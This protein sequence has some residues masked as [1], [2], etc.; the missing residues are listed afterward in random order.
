MSDTTPAKRGRPRLAPAIE[1]ASAPLRRRGLHEE[2]RAKLR[3]LIVEGRLAPG[4]RLG[5]V[6]LCEA[7]GVSRTPLREA[8]KLLEGEN[9]VEIKPHRGARVSPLDASETADLFE[10]ASGIEAFAARLAAE[11][12]AN[13]R[14]DQLALL[15]DRIEKALREGRLS[16]YSRLNAEIHREI[17]AASGNATLVCL[18]RDLLGRIERAR[19]VALTAFG[20][21]EESTREHRAILE[22]LSAGS[23]EAAAA[24]LGAHV[25]RTGEVLRDIL[26]DTKEPSE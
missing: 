6:E 18:H 10:A 5:E 16:V 21:L 26:G 22:A 19:R 25:R 17:V 14:L 8:L 15:Q 4:A 12:I 2:I 11:R 7:L 24:L 20:R 23:G 9:L 3:S 13:A 1:G